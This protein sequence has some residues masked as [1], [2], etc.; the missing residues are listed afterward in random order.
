MSEDS[1]GKGVGR[2]FWRVTLED[3]A[4]AME[5]RQS[6]Y[7]NPDEPLKFK[8]YRGLPRRPLTT[9]VPAELTRTEEFDER[10][11]S[12]LLRYGYGISRQEFDTNGTW[13]YHRMVAS[14][15]CLFGVQLY[16]CLADGVYHY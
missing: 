15:R 9:R 5:A 3:L 2:E 14:A 16:V 11:L 1:T 7:G 8:L 13:P 10:A 4:E 12:T 6:E